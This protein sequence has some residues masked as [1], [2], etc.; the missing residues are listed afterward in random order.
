MEILIGTV[1]HYYNHLGVAVIRLTGEMSYGDRILLL[2]HTTDFV[3][4]VS[5]MEI[6]HRKVQSVG[7]GAEVAVKVDE[8]VRQGD[9]VYRVMEAAGEQ[10]VFG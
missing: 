4:E 5:S 1:S 7:R 10:V 8:P 9:L 6:E 2:G 3:Q